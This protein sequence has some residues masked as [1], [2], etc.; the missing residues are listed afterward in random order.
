[1]RFCVPTIMDEIKRLNQPVSARGR[2]A[3]AKGVRL[4]SDGAEKDAHN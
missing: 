2:W 3:S 1:V 4:I